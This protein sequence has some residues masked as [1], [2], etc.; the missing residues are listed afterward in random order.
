MPVERKH[1]QHI[2][3]LPYG[4][5]FFERRDYWNTP[6]KFNAKELDAETGM[7][8]YGARYYT[9]EV[10]I[11]L[12][13]D[14]LAYERSWLSPYN[15]CQW[16]PVKLTDP[17]GML[18]DGTPRKTDEKAKE[19]EMQTNDGYRID[20]DLEPVE[21]V[22]TKPTQTKHEQTMNNPIVKKIH[23]GQIEFLKDVWD[24]PGV[25]GL[26][27]I[28]PGAEIATGIV[29]GIGLLSA[30]FTTKGISV[31][32]PR[33][34]YRETA[35]KIG[36]K[37]LNVSDD[38]WTWSKNEKFLAGVVKRGDDVVFAGKFNPAK[39]DPNS[40]LAREIKYLTERGYQWSDDFSR[41]IK[42]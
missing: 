37:F 33:A 3:Y 21:V 34:T 23:K 12:S 5:L 6:Y 29:K 30:K 39:L 16:N 32:G 25:Q 28:V 11:W 19:G 15:Y 36:A 2:E 1:K 24:N 40:V 26:L 9:P 18:D 17:T 14:P 42:K 31:I 20:Y 27:W 8:Y 10:S 4:E 22:S 7:Y 35:K 13:V 38:A 41:L